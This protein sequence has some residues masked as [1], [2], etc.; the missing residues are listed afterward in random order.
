MWRTVIIDD[1]V[2]VLAGLKTIIPWKDLQLTLVGEARDGQEG[3]DLIREVKPHLVITDI[4]MP[5][6]DGLEM[7]QHLSAKSEYNGKCV[8]LSGYSDFE[9]ARKALRLRIDEYLSKP[10]SPEKLKEV[11]K[12]VTKQLED[13]HSTLLKQEEIE[14]QLKS[15]ESLLEQRWLREIVVGE[16]VET[17]SSFPATSLKEKWE[18]KQHLVCV[19]AVHHRKSMNQNVTDWHLLRVAARNIVNEIAKKHP[20]DVEWIDLYNEYSALSIH[21]DQGVSWASALLH[22]QQ[23]TSEVVV[24][25]STYLKLKVIIGIGKPKADWQQLFESTTEAMQAL[26]EPAC[27]SEWHPQVAISELR[28]KTTDQEKQDSKE[29]SWFYL[30]IVEA[31]RFVRRDEVERL[32][33]QCLSQLESEN[34]LTTPDQL[35]IAGTEIWTAITYSMHHTGMSV[36][37]IFS[38]MDLNEELNKV[39][40]QVELKALLLLKVDRIFSYWKLDDNTR[41]KRAIKKTLEY[42]H[43]QYHEDITIQDIAAELNL[44]RNYLG[45]LF[46]KIVGETFKSYVTRVRL[47]KARRLLI[48]GEGL[49]VYQVAESVGYSHIPYFTRQFKQYFGCSPTK[50]LKESE[51]KQMHS[52]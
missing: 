11:L 45:Q 29:L 41:H 30:R 27:F 4:Y 28:E 15:Y 8:I 43:N 38:D 24:A 1:D 7:I 39:L 6:M 42:I 20:F 35:R 34:K 22:L 32:L 3:V 36:E 18:G 5:V 52:H 9:Y 33:D 10:T 44:S 50:L 13:Q 16:W 14:D 37:D 46:I 19:M 12:R 51:E 2:Q 47:E 26:K 17:N 25:V 48:E 23:M 49:L 40:F 31:I 21:F